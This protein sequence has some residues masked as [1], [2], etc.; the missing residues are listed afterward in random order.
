MHLICVPTGQASSVRNSG[1]G[2]RHVQCG[3]V[4]MEVHDALLTAVDV[5]DADVVDVVA[6]N[7]ARSLCYRH[8]R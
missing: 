2:M 8:V 7:V 6:D 4:V 1:H 3:I 5:Q